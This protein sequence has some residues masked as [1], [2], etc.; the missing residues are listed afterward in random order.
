MVSEK[1][2][3]GEK[4]FIGDICGFGYREKEIAVRAPKTSSPDWR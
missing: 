1:E 3:K 2:V 4:I